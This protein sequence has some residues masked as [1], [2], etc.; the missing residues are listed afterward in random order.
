MNNIRVAA[1][2]INT[3]PLDWK[4]NKQ[5]IIQCISEAAEQNTEILCLPELCISGYGCEDMFL[6][7]TT[8]KMADS[9]LEEIIAATPATMLVAVGLPITHKGA[10]YNVVATIAGK[11]LL[12]YTA[13]QHLAGD[14]VHYENRQFK[15][16]PE[17]VVGIHNGKPIGDIFFEITTNSGNIRVGYEICEDAWVA[18]R[19]GN[20]LAG[21]GVDIILNPSASHFS[22]GKIDIRQRFAIEGSRAFNCGY[23]YANLIGNE[24]GRIVYDGGAIIAASGEILAKGPRLFFK[25]SHVTYADIS[26]YS[27]RQK[28][29]NSASRHPYPGVENN[30]LK[31]NICRYERLTPVIPE[32]GKLLIEQPAAWEQSKNRNFE[33]FARAIALGLYHYMQ[34]SKTNGFV[35]SLSGGADSTAVV[36]IIRLM[37]KFAEEEGITL[38]PLDKMLTTVYQA[39]DN[40]GDITRLAAEVI[41]KACQAEHHFIN[42]GEIISQYIQTIENALGRKLTWETDDITLQNIQA[43]SRGPSVWMFANIKNQLLLSTS[44]RSEAAVGYA[45]MDGDTCG[46]IS[47]IS[48]ISKQFLRKWLA[49]LEID[50][51]T[52]QNGNFNI[53]E[54]HVVTAQQPTA[55]LRPAEKA[56]TDETDLMPY[57]VLDFIENLAIGQKVYPNEV[58][59]QLVEAG[60]S[61][62][63]AS[64][65]TEKFFRLWCRNQWKRERYA[66]GIHVDDKNLD[67]RSWCR[68][69]ILNN[70]LAEF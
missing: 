15:A 26:L 4:G 67:P 44:N 3:I 25:D 13:K 29:A 54:I 10:V 35:V 51:V 43:R 1:A 32:K 12:G 24:A 14:G 60:H 18:N 55:E 48:G 11:Q 2:C 36:C 63:Q 9:V 30:C 47:P 27:I 41:A 50:G 23:I 28:Q 8:T 45:T 64:I 68:F 46:S 39:S 69:P 52:T 49:W 37:H 31:G 59:A 61:T 20:K 33:E 58:I 22:F 7:P 42:V 34:K 65:W 5:K 6:S 21:S 40:S 19:P 56:Q 38:P 70:G 66:P 57:D 53:P 17:G 62:E 16:W